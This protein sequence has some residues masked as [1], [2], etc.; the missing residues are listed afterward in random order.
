K[1]ADVVVETEYH[2]QVQTHSALETHGAVVDWKGDTLTCWASTQ[3]TASVR[4]DFADALGLKK[5]QIRVITEFM[6]GGFGAKFGAGNPGVVATYLSQKANAPVW[7]MLDRAEEHLSV[8]SRPDS[9][10]TRKIGAEKDGTLTAMRLMSY[11]TAGTG[12]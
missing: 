11:G 1:A 8:G 4:D 5:S 3:G 6:G 10:Q 7:L 12:T 9:D 2:T